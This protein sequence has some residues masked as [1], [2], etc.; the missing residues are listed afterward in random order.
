VARHGQEARQAAIA[1]AAAGKTG[2]IGPP[3]VATPAYFAGCSA[4]RSPIVPLPG[5]TKD[6]VGV[7]VV[8]PLGRADSGR[9]RLGHFDVVARLPQR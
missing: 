8:T 1:D 2:G 3:I 4:T 9:S 5:W 6:S 7:N